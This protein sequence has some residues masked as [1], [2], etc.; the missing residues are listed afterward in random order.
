[1]ALEGERLT[2]V[3]EE[4][5]RS[6]GAAALPL[7]F[8]LAALL[9]Q[10]V[11]AA[12]A[13]TLF[14]QVGADGVTALRIGISALLLVAIWRPWR[15]PRLDRRSLRAVATYGVMLGAMNFSIYR[16]ME[17]IPIG[18]A[19]AIEV[20]G[21]LVVALSGCR[22]AVDLLWV[23]LAVTGLAILLPVDA[24]A[25]SLDPVGVAWAGAAATCWA[26]YIVFGKRASVLPAG[27]AVTWGMLAAAL[28]VAPIGAV[29]AGS[30][31]LAP[32]I[33]LIGAAVAV[34]SSVVPYLLEMLTL[35]RVSGSVF[36]LVISG[37]PAVAALVGFALLGERLDWLQWTAIACI[38]CA[39]AGST[40]GGRNAAR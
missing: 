16:A 22:R 10:Y 29:S 40:L 13:K 5:V 27:Q 33:L 39:S 14:P 21:P 18:L 2:P 15:G 28:F 34:L 17:L 35:R 20:A 4:A 11:G 37:A 26:L 3:P 36:G 9:S 31:L 1:M 19:V 6:P 8:L 24:G 25:G 38:V 32:E 12:F 30:V 7:L 23:A